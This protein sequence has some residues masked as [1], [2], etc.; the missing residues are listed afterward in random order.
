MNSKPCAYQVVQNSENRNSLIIKHLDLVKK[1]AF[2]LHA[3]LPKHVSIKDLIQSGYIG[4]MEA[5]NNFID[6]KNVP[7]QSFAS[8]RIRGA[9]LDFLR[10]GNFL[11][12]CVYK[13]AREISCAIEKIEEEHCAEATPLQIAEKL[14]IGLEEY[15]QLL[16]DTSFVS[17]VDIGEYQEE[18]PATNISSNNPLKLV[19]YFQLN[20]L[21][22][23][24]IEKIP[25]KERL[26]LSLYINDELTFK[27]IGYI[28][29]LSESRAC[30][31]YSQAVKR[32]QAKLKHMV[33]IK[34]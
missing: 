27:E 26:V 17:F 19:E 5:A 18:I 33:I 9:M 30:Q 28:M 31:L 22:R 15:Y 2:H 1:I 23:Q 11:P 25:K 24:Y 20:D 6:D 32:L 12:R 16:S 8:R 21:I 13:K 10:Q 4:L 34:E 29:E 7:F 14:G 3:R